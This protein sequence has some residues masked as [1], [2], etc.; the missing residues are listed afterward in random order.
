[1]VAETHALVLSR[2]G[3]DVAFRVL[4][5]LD[6]SSTTIVRVSAA[7]EL[8]ARHILARYTDETFS[9]TDAT[10]FAIMERL[11]IGQVFTLDEHFVQYGFAT[12]DPV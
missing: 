9:L 1:V 11:R 3:R 5:E 8:R 2:L 12:Y 7:D 4:A 6:A 10:S